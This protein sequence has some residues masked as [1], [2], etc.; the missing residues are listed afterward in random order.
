MI[1]DIGYW[2]SGAAPARTHA[3][4]RRFGPPYAAPSAQLSSRVTRPFAAQKLACVR[5][6]G[7]QSARRAPSASPACSD[8]PP[9]RRVTC[10]RRRRRAIRSCVWWPAAVG[11]VLPGT[12][13]FFPFVTRVASSYCPITR[14]RQ[15]AVARRLSSSATARRRC[16][17]L[18]FHDGGGG[19]KSKRRF[20]RHGLRCSMP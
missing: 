12:F 6:H 5:S 14:I 7:N 9:R 10:A 16:P 2:K 20:R 18:K 13:A 19:R 11:A 8:A 3:P 15:Q 4:A 1:S 17:S